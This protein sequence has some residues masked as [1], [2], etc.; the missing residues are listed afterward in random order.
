MSILPDDGRMKP[1]LLIPPNTIGDDDVKSLRDN[2]LCV[3]TVTDPG[4]VKFLDPIPSMAQRTKVENA[5]IALSRKILEPNFF[6]QSGSWVS[7]SRTDVISV[8]LDVL[9]K[10]SELDPSPSV[11]EIERQVFTQVKREEVSKI[12]REEAREEAA[13]RRAEKAASKSKAGKP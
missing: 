13:A 6:I 2:G 7:R 8:F 1:I 11:A 3:V 12:A 10:G 5:A 4:A 9:I